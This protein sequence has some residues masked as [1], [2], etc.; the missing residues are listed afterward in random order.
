VSKI[1][2]TGNRIPLVCICLNLTV[3]IPAQLI[4]VPVLELCSDDDDY[5]GDD[6]DDVYD[7]DYNHTNSTCLV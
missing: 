1:A 4:S 2:R 3:H 5:G 7:A 6:D